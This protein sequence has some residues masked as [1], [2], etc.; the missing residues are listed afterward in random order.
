MDIVLET[1]SFAELQVSGDGC[2]AY[3][4]GVGLALFVVL[5]Q[6]V[7]PAVEVGREGGSSVI[8]PP[9]LPV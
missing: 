9:A 2:P 7:A 1:L 8:Q 4:G 3:E 6:L 5:A